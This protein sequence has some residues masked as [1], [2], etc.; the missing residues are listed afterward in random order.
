M[1]LVNKI[2]I[3]YVQNNKNELD[4]LLSSQGCISP[5][6]TRRHPILAVAMP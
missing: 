5:T 1:P 2:Q 3:N 6:P 4:R